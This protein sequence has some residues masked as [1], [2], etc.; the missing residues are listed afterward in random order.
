MSVYVG[1]DWSV[2]KHDVAFLNETGSIIAQLT[3]VHKASGFEKLNKTRE[4]VGVGAAE[5]LVGLETAHN[6]LID[7]LWGRGY[8]QVYVI[9]P[10]VVKSSRGR[11]GSSEVRT[12]AR[13]A[14]LLADLLRTDLARLYPW[15]PD[16]LLTRQ[17]RAKVS[18][19]RHMTKRIRRV[20]ERLRAVLLRYNPG[21]LELFNGLQSQ[22]TV[23]FISQYS[24]PR[25]VETLSYEDFIAFGRPHRYPRRWLPRQYAKLQKDHPVASMETV[26][27]YEEEGR[28]LA[29]DLLRLMQTNRRLKR[30]L[31]GLFQEHP[32]Q[33][34]FASL[35]GAGE[36]LAPSLLA[37]FGED[38]ARFPTAGSVQA[39]A[40]TWPVTDQ[41][42]QKRIVKFRRKCD[43]EFRQI[44]QQ[45]ARCSLRRSAWA[46]AYWQEIRSRSHGDNDAYRRLG[47]RWLAIVW[48]LW[49]K[50]EAYDEAYHLK[51]RWLRRK[52]RS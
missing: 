6:L 41:S 25:E 22:I 5:C 28:M 33:H 43:K 30:E 23:D 12:D 4:Q 51:Q 36:L 39:L 49:Q 48:T 31:T 1:I 18:L 44:V 7:Y 21:V 24:T 52:P 17:I 13:D 26:A 35:P 34:I 45:W 38:R 11:Y 8:E 46:N 42:G 2:K 50:G 10:S 37:K 20:T 19:V 3:I 14:R 32:D 40:G 9:P 27:V 16:S 29:E 15:R 47:N